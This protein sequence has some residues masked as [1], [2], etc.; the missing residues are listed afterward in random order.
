MDKET[1]ASFMALHSH[2]IVESLSRRLDIPSRE[3]LELFYMSNFYRLYERED[4]K[5]WHFSS[6]TLTDLLMQEISTG[7]I[8]FPVEG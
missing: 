6:V 4:T 5:L 7:S 3:A 2:A 8:D 1:Y